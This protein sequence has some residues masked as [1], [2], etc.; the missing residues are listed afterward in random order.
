MFMGGMNYKIISVVAE[1][2]YSEIYGQEYVNCQSKP[3]NTVFIYTSGNKNEI[4]QSEGNPNCYIITYDDCKNTEALESLELEI[5][6]W[7]SGEER[8]LSSSIFN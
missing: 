5:L 3:D 7:F 2:E 4:R 6:A 1:E 8:L